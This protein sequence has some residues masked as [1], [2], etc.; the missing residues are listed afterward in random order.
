MI[1]MIIAQIIMLLLNLAIL[2]IS[3]ITSMFHELIYIIPVIG[4]VA[5][6]T[7]FYFSYLKTT[8]RSRNKVANIAVVSSAILI[9][10]LFAIVEAFIE[11]P[12]NPVMFYICTAVVQV[13]NLMFLYT[14]MKTYVTRIMDPSQQ[15]IHKI[16]CYVFVALAL[17]TLYG[18]F[19]NVFLTVLLLIATAFFASVASAMF[20]IAARSRHR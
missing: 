1:F 8:R 13:I 7:L 5:S 15:L 18:C 11:D 9:N 6:I 10:I 3:K 20:L 17:L 4:Y 12:N 2:I 14:Y 16:L 19:I